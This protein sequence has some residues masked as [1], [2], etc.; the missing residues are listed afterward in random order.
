V[1]P[2]EDSFSFG[3][4]GDPG[5]PPSSSGPPRRG[6]IVA[7]ARERPAVLAFV[8]VG[9][10]VLGVVVVNAL[11]GSGGS[12]VSLITGSREL[13]VPAIGDAAAAFLAD[14]RP[15]FVVHH[16]DG[17]VSVVDAFS[18]HRPFG[19]GPLVAWC[20]AS[21]TFDDI[22]HG[23]TFDEQGRYILG[24]APTGLVTF[25]ATELGTTPPTVRV[26]ARQLP[27]P[28]TDVGSPLS[29][30][31]CTSSAGTLSHRISQE[32]I[33]DPPSVALGGPPARWIAVAGVLVVTSD[34]GAKL[35]STSGGAAEPSCDLG[36]PVAGVD[37]TGLLRGA[38]TYVSDVSTW[39][40]R[41]NGTT[42]LDLTLVVGRGSP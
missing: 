40:V 11:G 22:P 5:P 31:P 12:S 20:A 21:R 19:V 4:S 28:R 33:T 41:T 37:G 26:G 25:A 14:G 29:G 13:R 8:A 24:P 3:S 38:S 39:L 18:T 30:S 16:E 23:S 35:C 32:Q 7:A 15:V 9:V 6:G 2:V 27:E 42:L 10:V 17:T 1:P 34:G 36:A